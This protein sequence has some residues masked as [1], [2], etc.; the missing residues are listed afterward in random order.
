MADYATLKAAIQAVI[1]ENGN[2]EITGSVMQATLLTIVN[3]LGANYQYAG[4]ATPSTN[5]G[6]PDQRVFYIAGAGTYPNFNSAI[7]PEGNIG[8]FKYN[9]SWVLETVS[10]GKNY[11]N[12]ITRIGL[13][14]E[15]IKSKTNDIFPNYGDSLYIIDNAGFV[16]AKID[17]D[18]IITTDI[19]TN[20]V[21]GDWYKSELYVADN[22]GNVIFRLF[23]G[24][25]ETPLLS[26]KNVAKNDWY[27]KIVATYGD[28]VTAVNN[29]DFVFPFP[30]TQNNWGNRVA[31]Y[32]NFA[33]QYGRGIGSTTFMWR[34]GH[35]G[36]V[37]WVD[38]ITGNYVGRNDSYNYDNYI[39]HV[40]IP[41]GCTPIRG[42]GCSWLRIKSMFP[43]SIKNE[44]QSVLVMFH[45][46][47]HQ[48]MDT[49]VEFI[50]GNT[51]DPEW[52]ASTEYATLGGDYNIETVQGG[53]ASTIMKLQT[54][55][56]NAKIIIMTPI[57][58]VY[59]ESGV[60]DGDFDNTQSALML[61]LAKTVKDIAMR[62][63]IPCIDNYANDGI[64]S[65]NRTEYIYDNIHPYTEK[66]SKAVAASIIGQLKTIIS[67]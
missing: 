2:Q 6:T 41:A 39:G 25:I 21:R 13:D 7:I 9:D 12:D 16:I 37:A 11:D 29:G 60:L 57:S 51:T 35:G 48:N 52:A 59:A 17:K 30:I 64:N 45:N 1:Y 67:L 58:G 49:D 46:D 26:A 5:P 23:N 4:V 33:K 34:N 19:K 22:N 40:T 18:G 62:M 32:F 20:F 36:Q 54:R 66:G 63:S 14:L 3:S 56:P 24:G 31:D 65:L 15:E 50:V 38:P 47:Y 61:K 28:S 53:I 10:V 44:I 27:N 55:L 42:D 43:D 8:L